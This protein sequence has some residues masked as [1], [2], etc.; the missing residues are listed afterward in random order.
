MT[1]SNPLTASSAA[2]DAASGETSSRLRDGAA[3]LRDRFAQLARQSEAALMRNAL[4]LCRGGQDCAQELVQDALV[5]AYDA[6]RK[7]QFDSAKST[8]PASVA[9]WFVRIMTNNFINS[10][11]RAKKW[12]AGV[13]VDTLTSGGNAGPTQTR[14]EPRDIP[15][16]AL[17]SATFDEP[18]EYA[19]AKL[20]D[21]LRMAVL[22]V[23]VQGHSYEEAAQILN[24]PV[25]TVRSRLSRARFQLHD[26]LQDYA[27]QKRIIQ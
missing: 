13:T 15:G 14:A 19:L 27:K 18:I 16:E 17:L 24:V 10:Y 22:L 21:S 9:A 8:T 1:P 20:S 3:S 5:R 6:F 23:D 26:L 12:D 11:R 4:R 2:P 7:G 25:G